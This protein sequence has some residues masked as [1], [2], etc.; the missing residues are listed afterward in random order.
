LGGSTRR[1][2]A[3]FL[4]LGGSVNAGNNQKHTNGFAGTGSAVSAS[5]RIGALTRNATIKTKEQLRI[6]WYSNAPFTAT[7]YGVQ[8]ADIITRFKEK[9]HEVAVAANYGLA[10]APSMWNGIKIF[11][12][13]SAP[14]SDDVLAAHYAEWTHGSKLPNVLFTLFD[15]WVFNT[16]FLQDIP[17]IVSWTPIDHVP[18]PPR[19][20]NWLH[21]PNVTPMAMSKFGL[22]LMHKAGLDAVYVP[23]GIGDTFKPTSRSVF[24]TGRELMQV[25]DDKFVVMMNSAN[26]GAAPCRKAFGENLLAFSIFAADKPDAVLYLHTED[27]GTQGGINLLALCKAVGLRE[28]QVRFVDQYAY[29]MN[30]AQDVLASLYTA[31]DVLLACSMG[32]G[33]GV[34]VVEAQACGTPVIVSNFTAQPE[35]VGDGFV[36]DA[37]PSWDAA[38]DAW[39]CVPFVKQ[40]VEALETQYAKPRTRSQDAMKF[41]DDYRFSKVFDQ[42]WK[43]FLKTLV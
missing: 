35:L 12:T 3:H 1:T 6:L 4:F 11:P 38:Q 40:I 16:S 34:P 36:V 22:D 27:R 33:F 43:P 9:E 39:F 7:G 29:K 18:I 19:V 25:E 32:E 10:G 15:V 21:Q 14:Y 42:Y 37:Q 31:S 20:L 13:G 26:K 24:G 2:A 23:H 8:T 5:S 17:R 41:A 28:D 30:I